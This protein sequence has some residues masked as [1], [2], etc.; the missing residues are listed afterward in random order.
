MGPGFLVDE[1]VAST[2]STLRLPPWL[3]EQR[4]RIAPA[5]T[6]LDREPWP[7]DGHDAG[8]GMTGYPGRLPVPGDTGGA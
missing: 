1:P 6:P 5:L 8:Q 2:G 7:H 4:D 3:E